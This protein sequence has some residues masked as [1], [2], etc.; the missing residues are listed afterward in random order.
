VKKW[1]AAG[2]LFFYFPKSANAP[3]QHSRPRVSSFRVGSFY[4]FL[5]YTNNYRQVHYALAPTQCPNGHSR[6]GRGGAQDSRRDCLEP[7]EV[8]FFFF[9]FYFYYTD[10]CQ[11][12]RNTPT[13]PASTHWHTTSTT[14]TLHQRVAQLAQA[15]WWV[16]QPL[17][18]ALRHPHVTC[19]HPHHQRVDLTRWCVF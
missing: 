4:L 1:C 10:D 5:Y 14:H 2:H 19:I 17:P 9:S 18:L 11:S 7:L 13:S 15:R 8:S 16:F 3:S 6:D 12:R